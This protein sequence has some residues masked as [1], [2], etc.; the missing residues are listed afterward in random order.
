VAVLGHSQCQPPLPMPAMVLEVSKMSAAG[1]DLGLMLS[2][3]IAA[4]KLQ[5]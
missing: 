1:K 3:V 4:I 2:A 5:G